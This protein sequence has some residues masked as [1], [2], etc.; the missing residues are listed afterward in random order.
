MSKVLTQTH[1]PVG[2]CL[3]T[4]K[5]KIIIGYD[6]DDDRSIYDGHYGVY[7]EQQ[8]QQSSSPAAYRKL[9]ILTDQTAQ[10]AGVFLDRFAVQMAVVLFTGDQLLFVLAGGRIER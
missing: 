8:K 1:Q 7:D 10:T 9:K 5:G 2:S 3:D 6:P 4:Y